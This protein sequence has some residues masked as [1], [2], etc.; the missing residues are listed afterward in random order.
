MWGGGRE[1][2][3]RGKER[4][5]KRKEKGGRWAGW[6][7]DLARE[8]GIGRVCGRLGGATKREI[9]A[10]DEMIINSSSGPRHHPG[11]LANLPL[12]GPDHPPLRPLFHLWPFPFSDATPLSL[13]YLSLSPFTLAVFFYVRPYLGPSPPPHPPDYR[14]LF[15]FLTLFSTS[16]LPRTCPS[17]RPNRNAQCGSLAARPPVD[18]LLLPSTKLCCH[19]N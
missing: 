7:R 15:S 11:S 3:G 18:R 6:G 17:P 5:K 4:E 13:T 1:G 14:T 10:G 9:L 12:L 8:R 16:L 19:N 2:E